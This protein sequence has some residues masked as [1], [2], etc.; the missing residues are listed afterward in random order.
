LRHVALEVEGRARLAD[1]AGG[2]G[3]STC[4]PRLGAGQSC[5]SFDD[6]VCDDGLACIASA[7]GHQGTCQPPGGVGQPCAPFY[8]ESDVAQAPPIPHGA[9]LDGL[10]CD[11]SLAQPACTPPKK[12]G[13][14]CSAMDSCEAG[15]Y[16]TSLAPGILLRDHVASLEPNPGTC[17]APQP[18][19][20]SCDDTHFC[21][22]YDAC[23]NGACTRAP[24][25]GDTCTTDGSGPR[26]S[27]GYCDA[28]TKQCTA[29]GQVG[30]ACDPSL[31]RCALFLICDP[32]A[33]VCTAPPTRCS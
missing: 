18:V 27:L 11:F 6:H 10:V 15:L 25:L 21:Q 9:C 8:L 17:V 26:C 24:V 5:S 30:D 4:V 22:A 14:A 2:I 12:A 16:C 3:S 19:G 13:E 29:W 32:Q 33:K 28:T 31:P 7:D 23:V 20:A 1:P